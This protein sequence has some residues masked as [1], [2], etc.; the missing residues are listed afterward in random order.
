MTLQTLIETI[1]ARDD[2]TY[3][4]ALARIWQRGTRS[5]DANAGQ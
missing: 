4:E 2:I 5:L 1:A 3:D